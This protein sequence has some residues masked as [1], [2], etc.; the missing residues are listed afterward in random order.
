MWLKLTTIHKVRISI[1]MISLYIN[2]DEM[3]SNKIKFWS[4]I[5]KKNF[6]YKMRQT[7]L[8][9][10]GWINLGSAD[11]LQWTEKNISL[12]TFIVCP[13]LI[14][15]LKMYILKINLKFIWLAC[16]CCKIKAITLKVCCDPPFHAL[17]SRL[18][19]HSG[20]GWVYE[21]SLKRN[22]KYNQFWHIHILIKWSN[23]TPLWKYDN[24]L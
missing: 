17:C 10:A 14:Y 3:K 6:I 23:V 24:I 21:L 20:T 1:L 7:S 13:G 4:Y 18:V 11:G 9:R 19:Y 5:H 16:Q 8:L 12:K 2:K 15:I 22:G